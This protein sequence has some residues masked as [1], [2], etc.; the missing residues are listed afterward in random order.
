ME[1]SLME[2]NDAITLHG[3][4]YL[5]PNQGAVL[6]GTRDYI[7]FADAGDNQDGFTLSFWF[8]RRTEC[9][10]PGR[11][12]FLYSEAENPQAAFWRCVPRDAKST[13]Q[14]GCFACMSSGVT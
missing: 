6:D 9:S 1:A 8:S 5:D 11:W 10:Q 13:R 14:P 2:P 3:N 12:E 7:T 4:A